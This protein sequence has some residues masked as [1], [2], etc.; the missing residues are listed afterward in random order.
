METGAAARHEAS[1]LQKKRRGGKGRAA[2]SARLLG[3]RGRARGSAGGRG[4]AVL[5]LAG[6]RLVVAPRH[7]F[8][9]EQRHVADALAG[10]RRQETS[11][12][13]RLLQINQRGGFTSGTQLYDYLKQ[14]NCIGLTEGR[15]RV[16]AIKGQYVCIYDRKNRNK[17]LKPCAWT[18]RETLLK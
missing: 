15:A 8:R 6:R 14:H 13:D 9:R 4:L 3:A 18:R 11:D 10:A 2:P 1:L 17:A 5:R 12:L 16:Y 7:G